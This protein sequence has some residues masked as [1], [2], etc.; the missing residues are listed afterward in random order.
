MLGMHMCSIDLWARLAKG[1][2][3]LQDTINTMEKS[4]TYLEHCCTSLDACMLCVKCQGTTI[5]GVSSVAHYL[6]LH[7]LCAVV[8]KMYIFD[9]L[10]TDDSK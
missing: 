4:C 6:M 2:G 10:D 5:S 7:K 1:F 8:R 9:I 3:Q